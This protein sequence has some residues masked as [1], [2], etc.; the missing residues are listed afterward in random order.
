LKKAKINITSLA[1]ERTGG[2]R[3]TFEIANRLHDLNYDVTITTLAGD[4][5]W[6]PLKVKVNYVTSVPNKRLATALDS[7]ARAYRGFRGRYTASTLFYLSR[8]LKINLGAGL[9]LIPYLAENLPDC[10]VNIATWYPTAFAVYFS[11]RGRPYYFVQD[12]QAMVA[13]Q[14]DFYRNYCLRMFEASLRLPFY[15][16]TNST[17]TRNLVT[18]YQPDAKIK[19]VGVGVNDQ[20]FYPRKKKILEDMTKPKVMVIIRGFKFKGD[21]VAVKVL[22]IV[23]KKLPIHAVLVGAHRSI[24]KVFSSVK[25]EFGYTCFGIVN[26]EKLATL[27]SSVDLFL[28]TSYVESFGLPPL[29][30]MAC[31]TPVVSTDCLGNRD[32]VNNGYNCLL[33]PTGDV[34]K[35]SKTSLRLLTNSDLADRLVRGGLETSKQFKWDK[36]VERFEEALRAPEED[37]EIR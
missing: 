9:D 7:V 35:I 31:G 13:E 30:A 27:Y 21:E 19:V 16:L 22:N 26:D 6:F 15:F 24:L 17:Y 5:S 11:W 36:V 1:I 12:F 10:D 20:C 4:Y 28:Y 14:C 18:S 33:T 3:A 29:E 8:L 37:N 34:E 25:P 32:Y 2:T 23:N